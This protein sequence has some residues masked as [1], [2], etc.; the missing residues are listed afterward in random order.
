VERLTRNQQAVGSNPTSGFQIKVQSL[1][2]G[3]RQSPLT[4]GIYADK[5]VMAHE[6]AL[7][8][9]ADLPEEDKL[10]IRRL[11]NY[12]TAEAGISQ[13]RANKFTRIL[14][15]I[16]TRYLKGSRYADLTLTTWSGSWLRSSGAS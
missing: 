1:H 7:M 9:K 5:V 13:N 15:L 6:G 2:L 14:W 8:Q 11:V 16:A 3:G 10:L 4:A 12:K